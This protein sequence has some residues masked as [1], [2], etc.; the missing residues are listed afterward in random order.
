Y[1]YF[2]ISF[3][4]ATAEPFYIDDV[5]ITELD[6]NG[7]EVADNVEGSTTHTYDFNN[8]SRTK[9]IRTT[10]KSLYIRAFTDNRV[11]I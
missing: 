3:K 10:P 5:K 4:Q 11:Q 7:I 8:V 9:E 2:A 6:S 1:T